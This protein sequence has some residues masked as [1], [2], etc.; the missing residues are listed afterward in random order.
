MRTIKIREMS[1]EKVKNINKVVMNNV[2]RMTESE[3]EIEWR[4]RKEF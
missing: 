4:E 3:T 1:R 2:E